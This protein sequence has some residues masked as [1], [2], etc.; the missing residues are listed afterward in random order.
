MEER[1]REISTEDVASRLSSE[2][3]RL[4]ARLGHCSNENEKLRLSHTDLAQLTGT[5]LSTVSR[6]LS[7]WQ[8]LGIITVGR[9]GI[10]IRDI[11]A[12][13]QFSQTD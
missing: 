6:L 4:S 7:R 13:E 3:I 2:L 11:A 12:L 1:L 5:T 10:Q 8:N 9:A